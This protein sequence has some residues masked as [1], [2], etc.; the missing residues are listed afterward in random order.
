MPK[1]KSNDTLM[2]STTSV[3]MPW[4]ESIIVSKTVVVDSRQRNCAKF[5][6]PS[7][8]RI[9]LGDIFKNINEIELKGAIIPKTS[10]NIHSSNNKIDFAIGDYLTGFKIINGGAGYTSAP[11]VTIGEPPG[12]GVQATAT[13]FI[14]SRGVITNIA[15]GNSGSGYNPSKPPYVFIDMPTNKKQAVQPSVVAIIGNH[16]TAELRVGEYEIGGNPVPPST[17]PSKLLLE[18]Q[19]AMNYQVNGG[20]YNPASTGPFAVR[21]VSQYPEIGAIPGTP[22]ATN[23][24]ACQFNRVQVTNVNSDVWEFIWYS[25]DSRSESSATILG[26]N[27]VDSGIGVF[28]PAVNVSGGTLIP[29]GTSIRGIY[30]Y[31]LLNDPD[32]VVL[33][34]GTGERNLDRIRSLD[35]GMDHRFCTLLFDNNNPDTLHDVTGVSI[36]NIGGVDQLIGAVKRGDFYRAAGAA[37]PMKAGDFDGSKKFSFKPPIAKLTTL[38]VAFTK[39]GYKAGSNP[40][41]YNM[42]G[43]EHL[44][45]FEF[46]S[47]DNKSRMTE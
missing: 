13:A 28:T 26:F 10:Y 45:L 36:E 15:I 23:T 32:Y 33:T 6:T 16:Y 19:N 42:E 27:T 21:L 34:I 20:M 35:D 39:F 2:K 1:D 11:N 40:R 29:A 22:E 3:T 25:G 8:Y 30:D 43:R 5:K 38:T 31:N 7:Y 12:M 37:K 47:S 18:I 9:D 24:N 44:L 41:F 4:E 14:N 46:T 17:T